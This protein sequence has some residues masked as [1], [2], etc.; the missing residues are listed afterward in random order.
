MLQKAI[1]D[2]VCVELSYSV[3]AAPTYSIPVF[4]LIQSSDG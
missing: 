2:I 1:Q 4:L 3:R